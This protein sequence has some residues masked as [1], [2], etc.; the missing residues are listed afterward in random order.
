VEGNA[1][2]EDESGADDERSEEDRV[3]ICVRCRFGRPQTSPRSTERFWRCDRS[4]ADPSFPRYPRIPVLACRG[5]DS[6]EG[7]GPAR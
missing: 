6:L 4:D 5:F 2:G 7:E 1:R 3:G